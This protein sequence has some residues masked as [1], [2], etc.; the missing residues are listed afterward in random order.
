M[1]YLPPESRIARHVEKLLAY[2]QNSK[3][4]DVLERSGLYRQGSTIQSAAGS[5]TDDTCYLYKQAVK[6]VYGDTAY[7]FAKVNFVL[8]GCQCRDCT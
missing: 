8:S 5:I 3:V 7:S 6:A 4:D 2:G 1:A